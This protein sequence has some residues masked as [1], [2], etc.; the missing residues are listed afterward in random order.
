MGEKE[1]LVT[2]GKIRDHLIEKYKAEQEI[3]KQEY[4]ANPPDKGWTD[5][6]IEDMYNGMHPID[7]CTTQ[8]LTYLRALAEL[9]IP[10]V[11]GECFC[12]LSKFARK[13]HW[14]SKMSHHIGRGVVVVVVLW[15]N[16]HF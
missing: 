14:K 7:Y 5:E 6:E 15:E 8:N 10:P 1:M 9:E 2:K 16:S 4:D 11:E 13:W 3:K 12:F